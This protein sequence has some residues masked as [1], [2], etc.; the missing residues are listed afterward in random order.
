TAELITLWTQHIDMDAGL[1]QVVDSVAL[2]E[3]ANE[4]PDGAT[5]IVVLGLAE[6]QGAAPLEVAQ[7]DIV[8]ERGPDYL[9]GTVDRQH[10][11]RLRIV[12][13]RISA[14]ADLCANADG[15]QGL[16]LVEHFGVGADTDLEVLRPQVTP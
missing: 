16:R 14:D 3:Q 11:F 6:Q 1:A 9:A 5:G 7:V 8:A 13:G 2:V 15:R 10:H 4:R 12:P